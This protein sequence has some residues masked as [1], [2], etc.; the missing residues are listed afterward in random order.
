M[1]DNEALTVMAK[2]HILDVEDFAVVSTHAAHTDGITSMGF[3]VQTRLRPIPFF[4][5]DDRAL[6][7]RRTTKLLRLASILPHGLFHLLW[8]GRRPVAEPQRDACCVAV[9]HRYPIAGGRYPQ[10]GVSLEGGDVLA[11]V[12]QDL[13]RLGLQ[14]VFFTRDERHDVVQDVH[15][16]HA[17]ITSPRYSL[18]RNHADLIDRPQALLDG[19]DGNDETDDG[20]VRVADQEP[21]LELVLFS[22]MWDHREMGEIDGGHHQ[23]H[24]RMLTEI[25]GVREDGQIRLEKCLLCR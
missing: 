12:A 15:A 20:A 14:L 2:R 16:A 5:N 13:L 25:F 3:S 18:H 21:S 9:H 1:N 11:E 19:R 8:R 4:Q 10:F 6:R 17:R 24:E 22:L 7:R 23:R